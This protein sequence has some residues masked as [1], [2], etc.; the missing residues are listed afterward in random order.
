MQDAK[1]LNQSEV[2]EIIA[3]LS[4]GVYRQHISRS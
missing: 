1:V 2:K 4:Y 3:L